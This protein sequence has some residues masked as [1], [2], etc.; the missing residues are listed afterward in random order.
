MSY[1]HPD[2]HATTYKCNNSSS[3]PDTKALHVREHIAAF[4]GPQDTES[5]RVVL[6]TVVLWF[7]T[8]LLGRWLVPNLCLGTLWGCALAACWIIVRV[9]AFVR[10]FTVMHDAA[11]NALFSSRRMNCWAGFAIG[12]L[13]AMHVPGAVAA[14][15]D[16]TCM[17]TPLV[18]MSANP[19]LCCIC[20][21]LIA[22]FTRTHGQ[23]HAVEGIEVS[24]DAC[25]L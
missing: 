17:P 6:V 4:A 2:A 23:H 12:L 24:C 14:A 18:C 20:L 9:G 25:C 10:S 5:A 19:G 7:G 15:L 3:T 11:H 1:S 21:T 16:N 13:T 22:D 8:L